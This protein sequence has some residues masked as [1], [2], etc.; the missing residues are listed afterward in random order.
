MVAGSDVSDWSTVKLS[1]DP[2]SVVSDWELAITPT[3]LV[4]PLDDELPLPELPLHPAKTTAANKAMRTFVFITLLLFAFV[5]VRGRA[6]DWRHEVW[7]AGSEVRV[8]V[9]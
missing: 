8:R 2:G 3:E 4:K 5:L 9:G 7:E 6:G 1:T